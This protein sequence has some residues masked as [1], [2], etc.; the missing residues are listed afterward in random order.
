MHLL[1]IM[2][3]RAKINVLTQSPKHVAYIGQDFK[4]VAVPKKCRNRIL[5]HCVFRVH[6]RVCHAIALSFL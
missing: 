5:L 3:S 2:C 1:E 4:Y 6:H